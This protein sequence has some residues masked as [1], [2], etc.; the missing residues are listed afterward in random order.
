M[1][2]AVGDIKLNCKTLS[3]CLSGLVGRVEGSYAGDHEFDPLPMHIFKNKTPNV[4]V[5]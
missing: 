3:I 4:S 2:E 1:C 5:V